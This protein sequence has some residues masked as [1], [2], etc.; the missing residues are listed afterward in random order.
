IGDAEIEARQLGHSYI[1]PEHL[2]LAAAMNATGASRLFFARHG[3]AAPAIRESVG[4]IL[5]HQVDAVSPQEPL[6]IALRSHVALAHAV[7][8]AS[9]RHDP[10]LAFTPNELLGALL[11]DDV[12]SGAVVGA[13]L[14]RVGLTPAT[15][16]A[17]LAALGP[18]DAAT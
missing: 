3:L 12:A 9:A 15:A 17:E 18:G 5:G 6:L 2:L 1:G 11:A 8:A 16:R 10:A 13:V 14:K 4:T 7:A